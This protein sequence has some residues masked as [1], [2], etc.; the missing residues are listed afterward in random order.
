MLDK[1]PSSAGRALGSLR[2]GPESLVFNDAALARVPARIDVMSPAFIDGGMLPERFTADGSG[3][4]PP[5]EWRGA[6]LTTA[7]LILLIEDPDA[8]M[9]HPLMHAIAWK[10]HGAGGSIVEGALAGRNCY[11][12]RN[13]LPPDPP[14]GHGIHHYAFE[15]FALDGPARF[16][17][18]PDRESLI[19]ML[20]EHAIAKGMLVGRYERL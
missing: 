14:S 4:S 18:A 3:I 1:I 6:P 2:A 7:E 10:L 19:E 5:L 20:K 15:L 17:A 13:Y 9:A 11:M 12:L 16:E 8:P